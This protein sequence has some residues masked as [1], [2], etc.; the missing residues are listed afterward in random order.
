MQG[1]HLA[2]HITHKGW[3]ISRDR[4]TH[5]YARKTMVVNGQFDLKE[6][7]EGLIN[8]HEVLLD[9]CVTALAVALLDAA[10]NLGDG[11]IAGKYPGNGEETGLHDGVDPTTHT[12]SARNRS[13]VD[14]PEVESLCPDG[15]T[16]CI[17]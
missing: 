1:D 6:L 11:L 9:D 14:D 7:V 3:G 16:H 13:C 5:R 15:R 10:F 17:G 4:S 2:E 12:R 8:R